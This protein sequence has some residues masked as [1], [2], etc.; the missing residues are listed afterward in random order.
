M[1]L[2]EDA[3]GPKGDGATLRR[4]EFRLTGL[5]PLLLLAV[6]AGGRAAEF[7]RQSP[8]LSIALVTGDSV[9]LSSFRGKTSVLAFMAAGC[10][11]CRS[12]AQTLEKVYQRLHSKGLEIVGAT[13]SGNAQVADFVSEL[14]LTFTVGSVEPSAMFGY[15]QPKAS[16]PFALPQV[17]LI[18]AQGAICGIYSG[19][20]PALAE[21]ELLRELSRIMAAGSC[22]PPSNR[23]DP[24]KAAS[25]TQG[26]HR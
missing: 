20:S 21:P 5:V 19:E 1:F 24:P 13:I 7:P 15:L 6:V 12:T 17:A 8:D 22:I 25:A 16:E 14:E 9:P 4:R 11:H 10:P 23:K 2:F 3:K 18:D 26:A